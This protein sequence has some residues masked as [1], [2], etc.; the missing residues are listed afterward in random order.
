MSEEKKCSGQI[1]GD[2]IRKKVDKSERLRD[3][4]V[5]K[6]RGGGWVGGDGWCIEV[7]EGSSGRIP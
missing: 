2:A 4:W 5:L 3:T 1:E 7:L 6:E